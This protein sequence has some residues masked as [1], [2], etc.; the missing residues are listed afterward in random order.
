MKKFSTQEI[1]QAVIAG[2]QAAPQIQSLVEAGK[3][4]ITELFKAGQ[5]SAETQNATFTYVDAV[6]EAAKAGVIPVAAQVMPD[7][8]T[9]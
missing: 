2:I 5:I 9:P 6:C 8:T 4:Y 1:I 3:N 7:P